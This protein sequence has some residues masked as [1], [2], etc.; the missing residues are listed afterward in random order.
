MPSEAE[1][2]RASM[3]AERA[4]AD[5]NIREMT[6]FLDGG[7]KKTE[8]IEKI[9]EDLERDPAFSNDD[10]YDLTVA[11]QRSRTVEK[12]ASWVSHLTN[13][14][15]EKQAMNTFRIVGLVDMSTYTRLGVHYG[16]F[17]STVRGQ[18]T[19]DQV[20]YW[21]S[22]GALTL[23]KFYG[24]FSMTELGHGSNVAAMET[25]ATWDERTDE[26]IIHT[27]NVR[28]TKWWIGGAAHSATHTTCYARL[29]VKGV[30]YGVKPI[31]VPLRN[32]NDHS[33]KPGIS[34]GDIGAK[35]GR[36][37]IDNGWIQFTNVRV[38]RQYLLQKYTKVDRNGNVTLPPSQQLVY[39]AL[40]GGRVSM[41]ADSF[42]TG[43]RF[44]TI[45]LRYA[46]LRR[47]FGSP[48]DDELNNETKLID[49]PYHQRRLL[50]LLSF[51]YG[52]QAASSNL[53]L[54]Y[55]NAMSKLNESI[56][57]NNKSNLNSALSDLKDLF[58]TS[59]GLKAFTTWATQNIIDECRQSCG[60][61]GYS[62]YNGFGK[63]YNDWVVQCT[64]EGDNNILTLSAGRGLIQQALTVKKGGKVGQVISYLSKFDPKKPKTLGD[65]DILNPEVL[66]EAWQTVS[67]SLL[68][69]AASQYE[70]I[71]AK[72]PKYSKEKIFELLSQE[73]FLTAKIHTRLYLIE[74]FYEN[75]KSL[76][77]NSPIK[78]NLLN[79]FYLFSLWSIEL[80]SGLFLQ[81]GFFNSNE[82]DEIRKLVGELGIKIRPQVIAL[83]DSF[84]LSDFFI[85]SAIG[86]KDGDIYNNYLNIVKRS[87]PPNISSKADY[88]ESHLRPFLFRKDDPSVDLEALEPTD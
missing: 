75:F 31:V 44:V 8:L 11:Q 4:K 25:T 38:P 51:V 72:N 62:S 71:A 54:Q 57:S 17:F 82:I 47:Q 64:W 86:K 53:Q 6:Y 52:M 27:P 48:K 18:G 30:D 46:V 55:D 88:Y 84:N 29:I 34:I 33:L 12:I 76:D 41:V 63:G 73:R 60:G 35:M 39:G 50:P 81:S 19:D 21:I 13:L 66:I 67:A 37:G 58:T 2:M 83:T 22:Q 87:Y 68:Y 56:S 16:L 61:H 59:A 9:M 42:V 43:K 15:S 49:Y 5:F 7:K 70:D 77:S 10:Y 79:L 45:A 74:S 40:I 85:N 65:R 23:N 69:K 3:A 80:E 78:K 32:L 24:C 1:D 36:D 28:A 14:R 20:S 26:F